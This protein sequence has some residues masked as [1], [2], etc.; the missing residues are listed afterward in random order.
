[1]IIIFVTKS[2]GPNRI[3]IKNQITT[4]MLSNCRCSRQFDGIF[5]LN[6]GNGNYIFEI[7]TNRIL[8]SRNFLKIKSITIPDFKKKLELNHRRKSKHVIFKIRIS[9]LI[10]FY[11]LVL[12]HGCFYQVHQKLS[13]VC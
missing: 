7:F 10:L 1:M 3:F 2:R 4:Y 8:V 9:T 11:Y 13:F 12:V 5:C 6:S